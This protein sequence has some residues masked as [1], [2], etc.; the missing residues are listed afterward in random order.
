MAP[1]QEVEPLIQRIL[2]ELF[3]LYGID[4]RTDTELACGLKQH[5]YAVILR[6][7]HIYASFIDEESEE[8]LRRQYPLAMDLAATA[9]NRIGMLYHYT[10]PTNEIPLLALH[11]QLALE[12]RKTAAAKIRCCIVCHFG[13]AASNLI[14]GRIGQNYPELL[15]TAMYSYQEFCNLTQYDFDVVLSTE[16][17]PACDVPV[18][19]ITL[20]RN[21]WE[22]EQISRFVQEY[23]IGHA[24]RPLIQSAAILHIK[25]TDAADAI[26]QGGLWL[27]QKGYANP[28]YTQSVLHR[29]QVS[30][31]ELEFIAV[32]HG[33]PQLVKK[34]ILLIGRIE[35]PVLWKEETIS[36]MFLLACTQH[37]VEDRNN[38][39]SLFFRKLAEPNTEKAIQLLA[40]YEDEEY[41]RRLTEA[42]VD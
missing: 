38:V 19:Y 18:I 39:F 10:V 35:P 34:T 29:E 33:N 12:R 13:M 24:L 32:P 37:T 26:R 7:D 11:F 4:L 28:G 17:L 5:V 42:M 15:V 23:R 36:T 27:E 1:T 16:T 9:A 14:C 21:R 31:T 41:R 25:A 40:P 30:S 6:R 3:Q 8:N 22:E 20:G 2:E